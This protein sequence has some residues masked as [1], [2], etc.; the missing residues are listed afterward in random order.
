M[1]G[2]RTVSSER[3]EKLIEQHRYINTE[4]HDWWEDVY[5]D[6]RSDMY[7]CGVQVDRMYFSGFCSQGDGACF[8]GGFSTLKAYLDHHHHKDQFPMIRKL[9]EHGGYV[10]LSCRHSGHYYHE[11]C[12]EFSTEHDTLYHLIECP[13]EFHEQVVDQWDRQLEQEVSDLEDAAKEQL[14]SYMQD[15]YRRLKDEHD[16]LTSDEAVWETIEANELDD[17]DDYEEAA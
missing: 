4:Y 14:R 5:H 15:L 9:L 1:S 6:F 17:E 8:E 13:T 10:Y 3:K 11:N 2:S 12:T 16:H 7:D